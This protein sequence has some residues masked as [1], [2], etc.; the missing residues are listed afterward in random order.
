M[1]KDW[2]VFAQHILK[3]IERIWDYK[4]RVEAGKADADMA[5]DAIRRLLET[6]CEAASD[7]LPD[8]I[9]ERHPEMEGDQG[10]A[11]SARPCLSGNR[12][13]R[14]RG[15]DRSRSRA[16]VSGYEI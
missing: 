8:T 9:K 10:N 15:H 12:S 3:C 11:R 14:D 2:R 4:G 5:S 16:A 13:R 6:I 7:K 1:S